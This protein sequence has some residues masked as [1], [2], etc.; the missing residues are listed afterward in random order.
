MPGVPDLSGVPEAFMDTMLVNGQAYP[1]VTLQPKPYRF[2][3]A[4]LPRAFRFFPI[5]IS[6]TTAPH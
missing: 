2:P 1:T 5:I 6:K 4:L 3:M